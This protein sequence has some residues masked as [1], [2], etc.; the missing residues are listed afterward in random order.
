M[1]DIFYLK[2]MTHLFLE[3]KV[4][5]HESLDNILGCSGDAISN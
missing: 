5:T 3:V 4:H 1:W 2:I